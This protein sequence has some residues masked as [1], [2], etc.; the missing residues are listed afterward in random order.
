[1]NKYFF[2]VVTTCLAGSVTAQNLTQYVQQSV[3]RNNRGNVN[4]NRGNITNSVTQQQFN[5]NVRQVNTSNFY[6]EQSESTNVEVNRSMTEN[7]NTAPKRQVNNEQMLA[8]YRRVNDIN[9]VGSAQNL[10]N[11]VNTDRGN[12]NI[13]NP[14]NRGNINPVE[15]VA[16]SVFEN[17]R[18]GMQVIFETN[19]NIPVQNVVTNNEVQMNI[20]P[21]DNV[22]ENNTDNI[23]ENVQQQQYRGMDMEINKAPV[24]V[25]QVKVQALQIQMNPNVNMQQITTVS[26]E[27]LVLNM[28]KINIGWSKPEMDFSISKK[29]KNKTTYRTGNKNYRQDKPVFSKNSLKKKGKKNKRCKKGES[30]VG[31]FKF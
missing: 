7:D 15:N 21:V 19:P 10:N 4:R 28:P 8:N 20:W 23:A 25:E 12:M 16:N 5:R 6:T 2:I 18:G 3:T 17:D 14:V 9:L 24:N 27:P 11:N 1:M 22:I 31:C 29:K 13:T 26:A 30:V